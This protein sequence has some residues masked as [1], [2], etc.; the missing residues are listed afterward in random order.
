M[1]VKKNLKKNDITESS[2]ADAGKKTVRK[3]PV[4]RSKYT[5]TKTVK[6]HVDILI[7]DGI[8]RG[9]KSLVIVESPAKAKTINK[10]LG[11]DFY[12]EASVGHIKNLPS[13]K[14]GVDIDNGYQPEYLVIEGKQEVIRKL[15]TMAASTQRVYIATDPDREGEAIAW[16]IAQEIERHNENLQRVLFNEITK[17]GVS[18]AMAN[19]AKL[20]M[21][22][23]QSQQARRVMDRIVGYKVSPFLW[24][25]IKRGTSAGRVQSVALRLVCERDTQINAFIPQEYWSIKA[26]LQKPHSEA[27]VAMLQT[28]DGKKPV[29]DTEHTTLNYVRDIEKK[30]FIV[31]DIRKREAKRNPAPPFITSSL[32]QEASRKCG[33]SPKM[34]MAV[35]QQLYE[36]VDTGADGLMG[37]I[38]YM[39]TDSPRVAE[40]AVTMVREYIYTAYG[41]D[42]L[43]DTPNDYKSKKATTQD[44]HE[45]IRPTSMKYTPKEASKFLTSQQSRLYELIWNRFVASQMSPAL[46]DQTTIEASAEEYLF[47]ATGS[48]VTFRGFLQVY[49]EGKDEGDKKENGTGNGNGEEAETT[50]PSD[51]RIHD[52]LDLHELIPEQHFTKPPARYTESSLIKELDNLGIGRPSTY[53]MMVG[54]IVDREYVEIR[55]RKLFSTPL[56]QSVNQILSNYFPNLFNVQFTAEMEE[57]L[58]KIEEGKLSYKKVL[59]DF[60]KP[61]SETMADVESR[62]TEVRESLQEQTGESC[63]L[64][65][66]PMI[67]RWGRYGR[68][69]ACS[70]YPDCKNVKRLAQNGESAEPEKTSEICPKCGSPMVIKEGKFGKFMACSGY[71]ACKTTKP[72]LDIMPDVICPKD[73]GQ[74]VRRKSRYGKFFYGCANYPQCDFVLWNEPVNQA[75]PEC[76]ASMMVKKSSKKKGNFLLCLT[77][78]AEVND[79]PDSAMMNTLPESQEPV[80]FNDEEP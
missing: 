29:L 12:V 44:A 76:Q 21:K 79:K 2:S 62:K 20:D 42:Y 68:F 72:I 3:S 7:P 59:D 40:S 24:T 38:T 67:I 45:A 5:R 63:E 47:R 6:E 78:N 66:K 50:L 30:S 1:T 26:K 31:S 10:Y 71:P 43:P 73:G 64:C 74:I 9:K 36:G 28:V 54:T 58:D 18:E 23:V 39:R 34:T 41:R 55:E 48:I 15:K 75:C 53:A 37:L 35:A 61:F 49:E 80:T 32:Q 16:H 46:M 56:G 4:K 13:T 22:L 8:K 69:T 33:F 52:R 14:I 65:G 60:Y 70:G 17:S 19:P 11:K 57:E 27:F 25:V 51:L 77:C